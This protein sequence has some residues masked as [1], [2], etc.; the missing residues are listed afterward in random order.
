[1]TTKL[2]ELPISNTQWYYANRA[3][4]LA[5]QAEYRKNNK[6]RVAEIAK[7]SRKKHREKNR[8]KDKERRRKKRIPNPV[9]TEEEKLSVIE[10]RKKKRKEYRRN[11]YLANR[12]RLIQQVHEY[13]KQREQ[14]DPLFAAIQKIRHAVRAAFKR[15]KKNKPTNTLELLGCSWEEAKEHFERLFQPGMTWSNH[16]TNGW[17]IDHIKPIAD[18]NEHE[19]HL[20]NLIE[21]LQPLWSE[22]H[23]R[24][25]ALENKAAADKRKALKAVK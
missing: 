12:E 21:N 17:H 14:I 22:D 24:K 18:F 9:L 15:I 20:A 16:G 1:M 4:V 8:L 5:Q 25:S 10:A 6:E 13:K 2:Q 7:K 3:K 11:Y 23:K 19:L